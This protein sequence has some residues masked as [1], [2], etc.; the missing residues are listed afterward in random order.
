MSSAPHSVAH[1]GASP[2]PIFA[3]ARALL[4]ELEPLSL[5]LRSAR[6][7]EVRLG[8]QAAASLAER[9]L[10]CL[11]GGPFA[12]PLADVEHTFASIEAEFDH[13]LHHHHLPALPDFGPRYRVL[14]YIGRGGVGEV[15]RGQEVGAP[16]R[17]VALKLV[18]WTHLSQA[19]VRRF[20]REAM[21]L[22]R[23]TH[24]GA[25][26]I[27]EAGAMPDGRMFI[28]M[29]YVDGEPVDR[30]LRE[31]RP[32]LAARL[33]LFDAVCRAVEHAHQRGVVHRDLKP[34]NILVPHAQPDADAPTAKVIDF[35]IARLTDDTSPDHP[36][37]TV[38]GQVV[39]TLEYMSPEQRRGVREAD[40]RMDVY[41]LGAL[42]HLLTADAPLPP[43]GEASDEGALARAIAAAAL[44]PRTWRRSLAAILS[45][46]TA[47]DRAN[48]YQSVAAL[49]SD[50]ERLQRNLP[51]EARPPSPSARA[52]MLARRR[53][54]TTALVCALALVALGS[55]VALAHS[56]NQQASVARQL[57]LER[58]EQSRHTLEMIDDVLD[59]LGTVLGATAPRKALAESLL[60]RTRELL[61]MAPQ[62][63]ALK[64]A[65]ARIV[66][67][68]GDIELDAGQ[69]RA[70]LG[71]FESARTQLS[72]LCADA[73]DDQFLA[74][75]HALAMVREG[76][77]WWELGHA[78]T[79]RERWERAFERQRAIASRWPTS[80]EALDDLT[81][82]YDRLWSD[83]RMD[84][85]PEG[86]LAMV[87]ERVE[88]AKRL[89]GMA[90]DRTLSLLTRME[91]QYR[92][93]IT[94]RRMGRL[95]E[96]LADITT[97]VELGRALVKAEPGRFHYRIGLGNCLARAAALS[98]LVN[99]LDAQRRFVAELDALAA[100]SLAAEPGNRMAFESHMAALNE[101]ALLA[102]AEARHVEGDARD[103]HLEHAR[104]IG[105]RLIADTD[106]WEARTGALPV[107]ASG[108]RA[109]WRARVLRPGLD[110]PNGQPR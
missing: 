47:P 43:A 23:L 71:L 72:A 32:T 7:A 56:R 63:A 76:D 80:V 41:A 15:F 2:D 17:L 22:G 90:P 36:A 16:H 59:R 100:A 65:E 6:L 33:A 102:C 109:D 95:H 25:A 84:R 18:T 67:A 66:L 55:F 60:E 106:A 87:R 110:Q 8:N 94:L 42:L 61:R 51:L 57:S 19:D 27:H 108:M 39:G 99:D 68:L 89:Q 4:D 49:R 70:A 88:L 86:T 9:M 45:R 93:A 53:P 12:R 104:T 20:T 37:V 54:R 14:G 92:L 50:V 5:A 78:S 105:R 107:A 73:P 58:D 77:A 30:W 28:A 62:D 3:A 35:G 82:A 24:A 64:Q 69:P 13:A 10:E 85:D 97:A 79:A 26:Q 34:S 91:G 38:T 29:E 11:D 101:A 40:T 44:A 1:A 48:R 21:A 31:R 96:A 46:A 103:R 74:R 81:W 52:V 83:E 75:T 98:D